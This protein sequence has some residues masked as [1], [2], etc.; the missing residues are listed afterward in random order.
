MNNIENLAKLLSDERSY[1]ILKATSKG[2]K[3]TKEIAEMLKIPP[4]NL[5]YTINKLIKID[6]LKV[7]NQKHIGNI[8]EN[9]YSSRHIFNK[10]FLINKESGEAEFDYFIQYFL[11]TQT[12]ALKILN[13]DLK[14]KNNKEDNAKLM[15]STIKISKKTWEDFQVLVNDFLINLE[16]DDV[17]SDEFQVSISAFRDHDYLL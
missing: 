11:I 15:S 10:D 16:D 8:I 9:T 1:S 12:K 6:A 13:K 17:N 2:E 4:S 7:E 3:T 5:Y 14:N